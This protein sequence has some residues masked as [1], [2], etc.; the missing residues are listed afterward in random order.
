M[1]DEIIYQEGDI[2]DELYLIRSGIV[3]VRFIM[4]NEFHGPIELGNGKSFGDYYVIRSKKSD[5]IY[6]T[7]IEVEAI[8]ITREYFSEALKKFPKKAAIMKRTITER[9]VELREIIVIY[10]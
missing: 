7:S 10:N 9:Y 1:R 3:I 2:V 8:G 6:K 5:F 4:D